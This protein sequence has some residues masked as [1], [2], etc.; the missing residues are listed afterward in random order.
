MRLDADIIASANPGCI[1]AVGARA[2]EDCRVRPSR[3]MHVVEILDAAYQAE[4]CQELTHRAPT[5]IPHQKN[6]PG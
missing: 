3:S 5:M 1:S 2:C 6:E 4:G